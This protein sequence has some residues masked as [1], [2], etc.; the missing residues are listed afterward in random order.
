MQDMP[1][2]DVRVTIML[3]TGKREVFGYR[4]PE[5]YAEGLAF[6]PLPR[7]R[8]IDPSSM[9]EAQAQRERRRRIADAISRQLADAILEWAEKNDPVR[10]YELR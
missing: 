3:P 6:T 9:M 1:M 7:D 4:W 10:G 2:L 8:E 5:H